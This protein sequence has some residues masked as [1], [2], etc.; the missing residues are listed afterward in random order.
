MMCI[1]HTVTGI[2]RELNASRIRYAIMRNYESFPALTRAGDPEGHTDIDLV[3]DSRD[4][5]R[6]R[7][8]LAAVAERNGWNSLTECDHWA[9]S[10]SRHHNIEAFRFVRTDP[11]EYLQIDVFHGYVLLGL[12]LYDEAGMLEG[13][14][15]D[16][17]RGLTRVDPVKENVYRLIQ[18][19]GLYPSA[20]RKRLRYQARFLEFRKNNREALDRELASKFGSFGVA[21]ADALASGDM[22]RF[23]SRMRL[24]RLRFVM[25]FA[26]GHPVRIL[27]HLA[28]RSREHML[29]FHTRQCGRLLRVSAPARQREDLRAVMDELVR[30]S[31]MDEWLEK[32]AD[33]P[34]S[35][36][37]RV[38]M[39]QGAVV[40]EWS[41]PGVADIDLRTAAD[42]HSI[43]SLILREADRAHRSLYACE[44]VAEV[45]AQ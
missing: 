27:R 38:A 26:L 35:K 9:Q 17:E 22:E 23:V 10:A 25:K 44:A 7:R 3:A 1:E 21:A 32:E 42:Q 15:D 39:E 45:T 30:K 37:H 41:E 11:L 28:R 43:A 19:H 12:P 29:R 8:A 2:L 14:V 13:R 36:K 16:E 4:L 34:L 18:I 33:V 6:L 40:I 5:D 31:F 20:E 24:A